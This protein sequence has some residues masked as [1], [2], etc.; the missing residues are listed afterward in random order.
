M[1]KQFAPQIAF[2][3]GSHRMAAVIHV[4]VANSLYG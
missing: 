1:R 2:H 3:H 4:K